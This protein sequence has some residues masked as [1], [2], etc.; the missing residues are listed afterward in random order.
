V[1]ESS[2]TS[3]LSSHGV[4]QVCPETLT[5][6]PGGTDS[7]RNAV[8]AGDDLRKSRADPEHA[9][10]VNPHTTNPMTLSHHVIL[11]L[12]I[13]SLP[14]GKP[15]CPC[16]PIAFSFLPELWRSGDRNG[17][18]K[19]SFSRYS[20]RDS[21]C[22]GAFSIICARL[23]AR[24]L[25]NLAVRA[26][27]FRFPT[28]RWKEGLGRDASGLISCALT[29][30]A[31]VKLPSGSLSQATSAPGGSSICQA[32]FGAKRESP[33]ALHK[34]VILMQEI[35]PRLK[36]SALVSPTTAVPTFKHGARDRV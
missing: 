15:S 1:A 32:H 5:S 4:R 8:V 16:W 30:S 24:I 22:E 12:Y 9:A 35:I 31:T 25:L 34:R 17:A 21:P 6:A 3:S 13:V 36:A 18:I 33:E 2:A 27:H 14:L 20:P 7:N 29:G 23:G 26:P 10:N 28:I 11:P 19:G